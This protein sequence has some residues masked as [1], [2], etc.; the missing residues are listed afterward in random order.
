ML[1]SVAAN[2]HNGCVSVSVLVLFI[3]T[4]RTPTESR[5]AGE[6]HDVHLRPPVL[7]SLGST[8]VTNSASNVRLP[9][10]LFAGSFFVH[11]GFTRLEKKSSNVRTISSQ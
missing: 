11:F 1:I 7:K 10:S 9:E 4:P 2:T 8:L 3:F 5:K 6:V